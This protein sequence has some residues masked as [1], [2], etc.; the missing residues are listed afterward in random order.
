[1]GIASSVQHRATILL[2]SIPLT[3]AGADAILPQFFDEKW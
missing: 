1:M 3:E 2:G